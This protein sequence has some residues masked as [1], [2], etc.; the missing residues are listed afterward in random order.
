MCTNRVASFAENQVFVWD[1]RNFEKPFL[2]MN[3]S[4]TISKLG[5]CP[6]RSG[7]LACLEKDSNSITLH[8]VNHAVMSSEEGDPAVLER[9]LT[10]SYPTDMDS[11]DSTSTLSSFAWHPTEEHLITTAAFNGVLWSSFVYERITL[12]WSP[13]SV[14][15]WSDGK[16]MIHYIDGSDDIYS[17]L[18]DISVK[19]K[20]RAK[21]G[22]GLKPNFKDN[23]K[24]VEDDEALKSLWGWLEFC[25][26]LTEK[27]KYRL[28]S[29]GT[30]T[31][32]G[33]QTV[34]KIDSTNGGVSTLK[35]EIIN[36]SSF[37]LRNSKTYRY[38]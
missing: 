23:G 22:Y 7:L 9:R 26:T 14:M 29:I 31:L 12:N 32:P 2:V 33:A 20:V 10:P 21:S 30:V 24:L 3:H 11:I 8:D 16:R 37:D 27:E 35:S 1:T 5:W 25:K 17:V 15:G 13:T 4:K 19:M 38:G 6:T 36:N 18:D 34:L 28:P